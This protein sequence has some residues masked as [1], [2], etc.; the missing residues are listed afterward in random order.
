MTLMVKETSRPDTALQSSEVIQLSRHQ[1]S[2][3]TF[4]LGNDNG[5][6][7]YLPVDQN[8]RDSTLVATKWFGAA[9]FGHFYLAASRVWVTFDGLPV[10]LD[11]ANQTAFTQY[12]DRAERTFSVDGCTIRETFLVPRTTSAFVVSLEADA[13]ARFT[14]EPQFDMRYYQSFNTDFS[15]YDFDVEACA[16]GQRLRVANHIPGP[17]PTVPRL[18]FYALVQSAS[19]EATV[20]PVPETEQFHHKT[21]LKDEHREK[22]IQSAYVET[23]EQVPDEAPI[24]DEYSTKTFVPAHITGSGP[25]HLVFAFGDQP[26]KPDE[27]ASGIVGR[28]PEVRTRK[29]EEVAARRRDGRLETGDPDVDRAYAQ[30][31]AR[32][33][34]CLVAR[35]MPVKVADKVERLSAIFAGNKYFLDAWKRDENISLIG[36]LVTGEYATVRAILSDTWQFQDDRTGRLPHI[37]RLGEPLVYFSSDGTLWAL[38]RLWQYTQQS[39][40]RSLLDAKYSMVEHFFEASLAFVQRGLLPSGGIVE[41]SYLWETWED[42]PYTPRAGY[43]VEIELLWLS[44]LALYLPTVRERNPAL[45]VL[46]EET[47]EEGQETFKLFHLDGFLADSLSYAWEP[48]PILTPNGY[49]AFGLNHPLPLDLAR[50]MIRLGREQLA[51]HVGVRSLAPRDWSRVLS[52]EF[53]ADPHNFHDE[54]MASVGIYNYHRGIEWLWLNQYFVDGE[55]QYGDADHAFRRYLAGQV[56]ETLHRGGVGGLSE[57]YDIRGPLGADFQAWSMAGFTAGLHAFAGVELDALRREISVRPIL[58]S[59]WPHLTCRR[60]VGNTSFDLHFKHG[61]ERQTIEIVTVGDVPRGYTLCLGVRLPPNASRITVTLNG[62]NVPDDLVERRQTT[63]DV[64]EAWIKAPFTTRTTAT[65]DT[66]R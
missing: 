46:L 49:I 3:R 16:T 39:G 20:E 64:A 47:L 31:L 18:D 11:R 10:K 60:S 63:D 25:L 7:L 9:G 38:R 65:F 52:P 17:G 51:G 44:N 33:N 55:L 53:M 1:L 56:H 66:R 58:P 19:G 43:P 30:V 48:Q 27:A 54:N 24:W 57:L 23:H 29:R 14:V 6:V 34:D 4:L 45:A 42:T 26:D 50:S 36:L 32:F 2:G 12:L 61:S 22:L 13:P 37:I 59:H 21:Y 28:L 5:F 40:D 8:I 35:D 62:E 41:K 15:G